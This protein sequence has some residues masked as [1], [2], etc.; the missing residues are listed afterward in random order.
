MLVYRDTRTYTQDYNYNIVYIE[1]GKR[2]R[3]T[4]SNSMPLDQALADIRNCIQE[5]ESTGA[6]LVEVK[7]VAV[8]I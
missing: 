1:N 5:I 3:K 8:T 6:T 7:L 4:N 2:T